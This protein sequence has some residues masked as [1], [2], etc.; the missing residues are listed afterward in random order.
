M[1]GGGTHLPWLPLR[2]ARRGML[3]DNPGPC[4]KAAHGS[5]GN[6]KGENAILKMAKVLPLVEKAYQDKRA[7]FRQ[8]VKASGRLKDDSGG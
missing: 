2:L 5:L 4:A 8:A 7:F 3:L 6:Y 1:P